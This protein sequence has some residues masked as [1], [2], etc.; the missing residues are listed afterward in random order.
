MFEDDLALTRLDLDLKDFNAS[1]GD[2]I[3]PRL[4]GSGFRRGAEICLQTT[5]KIDCRIKAVLKSTGQY[6]RIR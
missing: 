2:P 1:E 3:N 4:I 5:E 6:D